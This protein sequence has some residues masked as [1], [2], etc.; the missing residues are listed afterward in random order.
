M[1]SSLQHIDWQDLRL[2]LA[3]A[4][5][6]SFSAAART[7]R[8]GQPTL[9]RRMA[10]LEAQLGE[11]L[12]IRQSQGCQL[13]PLAERLL[14]AAQQ[15]ALWAEEAQGALQQQPNRIKGKVR[16]TAPPGIAFT[17]LPKI[18]QQLTS[19]Y[20]DI[21]LEVLSGVE[22]YNLARGEADLA[23]RT[24]LNPQDDLICLASMQGAMQVYA[25]PSYAAMLAPNY[26]LADL[27]W[28]CWTPDYD[29]LQI[30]Q[31]LA[32][33]IDN[34][35]PAFSANDFN[36]QIAACHSGVGAMVLPNAL[37]GYPL[38]SNLVPLN[39]DIQQYGHAELHLLA[40]KRQAYLPKVQKVVQLITT[41]FNEL[42]LQSEGER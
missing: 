15:M 26:R 37:T 16:I 19:R 36:V 28:I 6:G 13:T 22:R 14:P 2:F 41:M 1:N 40:H 42:E 35:Q 7:L 8:L 23:L 31:V 27:R 5:G 9:S 11:A 20:P 12:F 3:V 21:Q 38:L 24:K 4:E 10:E 17:L 18:A 32:Q 30:N 33:Q 39:I 29:H 25:A 34:F